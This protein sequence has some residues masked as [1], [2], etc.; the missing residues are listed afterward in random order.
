MSFYNCSVSEDNFKLFG[1]ILRKNCDSLHF[2][3]ISLANINE[4]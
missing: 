1:K 4:V 3:R 2:L